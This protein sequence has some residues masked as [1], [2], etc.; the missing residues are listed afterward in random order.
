MNTSKIKIVSILGALA[1]VLG[2]F[3]AHSLKPHLNDAQAEVFRTA[4]MYHFV[5]LMPMMVIAFLSKT[6]KALHW[7]YYLFLAG[8][9]C[10]SGSL[11]LL[12]TKHMIG[13]EFWHI[14]GPITPVGGLLFIA[15]WLNL[16]RWKG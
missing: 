8:I 11:Y 13:G 16:F 15:G 2:A 7:S 5:H 6:S 10:F 1:V 14:V 12:S 3:G 9:I 4:T